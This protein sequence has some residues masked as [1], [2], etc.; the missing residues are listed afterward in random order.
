VSSERKVKILS[1]IIIL[2]V[3]NVILKISEYLGVAIEPDRTRGLEYRL[4]QSKQLQSDQHI[5]QIMNE[6]LKNSS[7]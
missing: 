6:Q 2:V 5:E 4:K 7:K 3:V 1:A